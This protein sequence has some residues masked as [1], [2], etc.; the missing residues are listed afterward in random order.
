MGN[1]RMERSRRSERPRQPRSDAQVVSVAGKSLVIMEEE[2]YEHLLDAVDAAEAKRISEDASD[3]V[4]TWDEVKDELIR[5]RIAK[6]RERLGVTQKELA[7][8]LGVRQSTV[9]RWERREAN[10]TLRTVRRIAK[11]LGCPE[12]RL[13][14]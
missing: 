5:N 3:P 13:I 12:H 2:D 9:S 11:A 8:R 14:S 10:L 6:V 4:L 7:R 1:R